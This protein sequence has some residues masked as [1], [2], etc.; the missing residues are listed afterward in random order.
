M[1]KETLIARL[2]NGLEGEEL[3]LFSRAASIC[4]ATEDMSLVDVLMVLREGGIEL[5]KKLLSESY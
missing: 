2:S 5:S 4:E 1:Y 3:D